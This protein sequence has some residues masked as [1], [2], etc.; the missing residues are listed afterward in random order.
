MKVT[1]VGTMTLV[2][3][4][5]DSMAVSTALEQLSSLGLPIY[6]ADGGSIPTLADHV[7]RISQLEHWRE[8]TTLVQQ[9]KAC[10]ARAVA[11]KHR[12]V[13]Y[14]EP[15][16][17]QF[18]E[19][20]AAPFLGIVSS[21]QNSVVWIAA[22]S[23]QDLATFPPGQQAAERAFNG[24]ANSVLG[25]T[26]DLLYGPLVLDLGV[27]ADY[28][29]EIPDDI[30]WGWRTYVIARCVLAGKRVTPVSGKF[31]CPNDQRNEDHQDLAHRLMQLRQNVEG[32]RLAVMQSP[33]LVRSWL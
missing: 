6:A 24:L 21:L 31:T 10:L 29:Q 25:M 30:G 11:N 27:V 8:G 17:K 1:A 20:A 23:E 2:R 16:K 14:T 18:F 13:L 19:R 5:S 26:G 12:M 9:I 3:S 32:L 33:A 22:R 7:D 15:D 4:E 28:L